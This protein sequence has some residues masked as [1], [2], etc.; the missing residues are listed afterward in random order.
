MYSSELF[1]KAVRSAR[2]ANIENPHLE[3]LAVLSYLLNKD[4]SYLYSHL[5]MEISPQVWEEFSAFI[6]KRIQR[7]PL[8]YITGKKEFMS[9]DFLV[10]E[11]VLIPRP[12]TEI[13]VE[14]VLNLLS[15][16]KKEHPVILDMGTG[17]GN[18]ALSLAYYHKKACVY[19]TDISIKAL[20]IAVKNKKNLNLEKRVHFINCSL[21]DCFN[22][23]NFTGK[24]D[25][26]TSNPPYVKSGQLNTLS[27]ELSYE[28]KEALDGGEDGL[29]YYPSLIKGAEFLLKKDGYLVMEI[30]H[31]QSDKIKNLLQCTKSFGDI[32]IKKD[33][34]GID[35]VIITR[36]EK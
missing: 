7:I 18:I 35:R 30:G 23:K 21:F 29:R 17:C 32:V 19:A 28:P 4:K 34:S 24:V 12:E 25:I 10:N 2:T 26:L 31:G 20:K 9:L 8:A 11:D 15:M 16:Q 33:Y 14:E 22:Q 36:R 5:S 27:P 1:Y 3:S 13:L 6:E